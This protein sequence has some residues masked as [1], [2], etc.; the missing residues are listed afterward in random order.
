MTIRYLI[1]GAVAGLAVLGGC[2]RY[3]PP[4]R[5]PEL[6]ARIIALENQLAAERAARIEREN[7]AQ[8][9]ADTEAQLARIVQVLEQSDSAKPTE[10]PVAPDTPATAPVVLTTPDPRLTAAAWGNWHRNFYKKFVAKLDEAAA[11]PAPK[12]DVGFIGDTLPQT[13]FLGPTGEI[14]DLDSF[15]GEK[16]VVLVFMRGFSGSVCIGCSTQMVSLA[17]HADDFAHRD[18]QVLIVYPGEASSVPQFIKAVQS[19]DG[20]FELPYPILLDVNLK[21]VKSFMIEGSLAKPT[22]LIIDKQGVV[23]WAYVGKR[24]DDRPSTIT[25]LG[26]LD[27][28][29]SN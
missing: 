27:R 20:G 4:P 3:T 24:F 6:E 16:N 10:T 14:V 17:R 7:T 21:A 22:S 23:R 15:R 19:L 1:L 8:R 13:R 5:D 29:N 28:L 25:L 9:L 26:E 2:A 11:T 12:D 18:T